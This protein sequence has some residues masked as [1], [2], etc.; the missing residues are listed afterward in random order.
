MDLFSRRWAVAVRTAV[1][2]YFA[3][4]SHAHIHAQTLAAFSQA[5]T[6][7]PHIISAHCLVVTARTDVAVRVLLAALFAAFSR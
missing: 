5:L 4:F 1:G 3:L 7:F 6:V 2:A